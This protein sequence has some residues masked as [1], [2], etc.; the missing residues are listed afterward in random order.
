MTKL[1][2]VY[3][4]FFI[5]HINSHVSLKFI[6]KYLNYPSKQA[7]ASQRKLNM[8]LMISRWETGFCL[9]M[10]KSSLW[11]LILKHLP[12]CVMRAVQLLTSWRNVVGTGCQCGLG[13]SKHSFIINLSPSTTSLCDSWITCSWIY[14]VWLAHRQYI[15]SCNNIATGFC[16]RSYRS[17]T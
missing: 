12:C 1:K 15:T 10:D 9:H 14:T 8:L 3:L 6:Y 2:I 11:P 17:M 13:E 16:Q 4:H 5:Y 7:Q